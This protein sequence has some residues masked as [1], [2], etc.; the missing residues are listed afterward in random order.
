[1][2]HKLRVQ[3]WNKY[4]FPVI[5]LKNC[6]DFQ[7]ESEWLKTGGYEKEA[8]DALPGKDDTM[9]AWCFQIEE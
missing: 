5:F 1:M 2:Y 8:F 9:E 3:H 6:S 4:Q 7:E